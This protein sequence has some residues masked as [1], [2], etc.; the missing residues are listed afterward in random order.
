MKPYFII[1]LCVLKQSVEFMSDRI[2]YI[3]LQIFH[4]LFAYP[5]NMFYLYVYANNRNKN[6]NRIK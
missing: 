3:A 4:P 5:S 6:N 2:S 1:F